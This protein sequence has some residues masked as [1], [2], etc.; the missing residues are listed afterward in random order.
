MAD[1]SD[2]IG[3]VIDR[4]RGIHRPAGGEQ[5]STSSAMQRLMPDASGHP[6]GAQLRGWQLANE[7]RVAMGDPKISYAEWAKTAT[8]LYQK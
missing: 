3:P 2:I 1:L 5:S 6:P 8:P 4:L 7:E